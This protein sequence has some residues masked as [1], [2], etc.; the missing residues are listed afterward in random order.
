M[1]AHPFLLGRLSPRPKTYLRLRLH[2]LQIIMY[3]RPLQSP[4]A[5]NQP[6]EHTREGPDGQKG[7]IHLSSL[8]VTDPSVLIT[9][10]TFSPVRGREGKGT[11]DTRRGGGKK[12]PKKKQNRARKKTVRYFLSSVRLIFYFRLT[13]REMQKKKTKRDI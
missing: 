3:N 8:G 13:R 9:L 12:K 7:E 6:G 10:A 11:H 4:P 2:G 5:W 1:R